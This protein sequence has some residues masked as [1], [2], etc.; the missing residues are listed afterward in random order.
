MGISDATTT[1]AV[2]DDR[3]PCPLPT[4][5]SNVPRIRVYLFLIIS[6]SYARAHMNATV[7]SCA[8][9][10]YSLTGSQGRFGPARRESL[11]WEGAKRFGLPVFLLRLV[12]LLLVRLTENCSLEFFMLACDVMPCL[13]TYSLFSA[14]Q[15]R[16][17]M[18]LIEELIIMSRN[19]LTDTAMQAVNQSSWSCT[20]H[21]GV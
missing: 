17:C 13:W 20:T 10:S 11:V 4:A 21:P 15:V 6:I 2:R 14:R 5:C 19:V 16:T 12:T 1:A 18:N 3:G 8:L 7:I 9:D